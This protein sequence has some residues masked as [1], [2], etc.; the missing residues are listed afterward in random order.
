MVPAVDAY[1]ANKFEKIL[2][3]I[4]KSVDNKDTETYLIDEALQGY[5]K[6][7]KDMFKKA[8][9]V[10]DDKSAL[11]IDVRLSYPDVTGQT[12]ASYVITRGSAA[13]DTSLGGIGNDTGGSRNIGR[14]ATGENISNEY[15]GITKDEYGYYV[16]TEYPILEMLGVSNLDGS[17]MDKENLEI[18]S[19]KFRLNNPLLNDEYLGIPIHIS[20]VIQ[21]SGGHKDYAGTTA[22][23]AMTED[24]IISSLGNNA[25]ITRELDSLLKF[26]L[27]YMRDSGRE[28]NYYQVPNIKSE[29]LG[30]LDLG[31]E[32][33]S[34][35]Y[36]INTT[37]TYK[38]TYQISKDSATRIKDIEFSLKPDK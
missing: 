38:T 24:V 18:G 27:I 13:E 12:L 5:T 32:A 37:V 3:A 25:L 1:F 31:K 2:R 36:T 28:S 4:L 14:S 34:N 17:S 23:Y 33:D 30:L 21:D 29:P 20:Y 11:P 16:K 19:N 22:G 35:I 8:Y 6:R 26:I 10:K 15:S 7:E 9:A